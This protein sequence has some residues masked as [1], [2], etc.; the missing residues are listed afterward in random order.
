MNKIKITIFLCVILPVSIF[1]QWNGIVVPETPTESAIIRSSEVTTSYSIG[2]PNIV[3]PFYTIQEGRIK[4]PI[5]LSYNAG[6]FKVGEKA[7]WV[8][9]GWSLST[10]GVVTREMRG[11][12]D[13]CTN[14]IMYPANEFTLDKLLGKAN[15]INPNTLSGANSFYYSI[16]EAISNGYDLFTDVF[17]FSFGN[18]SGKLV[19]DQKEC[20]FLLQPFSD[21]RFEQVIN[22]DGVIEGWIFYTPDGL[23]YTFGID[24]TDKTGQLESTKSKILSYGDGGYMDSKSSEIGLYISA[25]YLMKITD[26]KS[27]SEVKF[28]YSSNSLKSLVTEHIHTSQTKVFNSSQPSN[29][30]TNTILERTY[31]EKQCTSITFSE[32][33]VKFISDSK[34]RNDLTNSHALSRLELHAKDDVLKKAFVFNYKYVSGESYSPFERYSNNSIMLLDIID[35]IGENN[36]KDNPYQFYYN[37]IPLPNSMSFAQDFWGF[38]NGKSRASSLIP[39]FY[40]NGNYGYIEE[41]DRSVSEKYSK[42]CIL[43]KIVFPTGGESKF[44]YENNTVKTISNINTISKTEKEII[45][46]E[47]SLPANINI[48]NSSELSFELPERSLVTFNTVISKSSDLDSRILNPTSSSFYYKLSIKTPDGRIFNLNEGHLE[49]TLDKGRYFLKVTL[50]NPPNNESIDQNEQT[51]MVAIKYFINKTSD[52][53]DFIV[54]GLRIKEIINNFGNGIETKTKYEY[55]GGVL[56]SE[57]VFIEN[58]VSYNG[59][60]DHSTVTRIHSSSLTPMVYNKGAIIAYRNVREILVGKEDSIIKDYE[61][62]THPIDNGVKTSNYGSSEL[63]Y[64]MNLTWKRGELLSEKHYKKTLNNIIYKR[65]LNYSV[66]DY[67]DGISG[68]NITYGINPPLE[69][70]TF[71]YAFCNYISEWYRKSQEIVTTYYNGDSITLTKDYIYNNKTGIPD[72]IVTKCNGGEEFK[73]ILY[74]P[75]NINNFV[76]KYLNKEAVV[77]KDTCNKYYSISDLIASEKY[78]NNVLV[79]TN[80]NNYVESDGYILLD[81]VYSGYPMLIQNVWDIKYDTYGN[82]IS[83]KTR[84]GIDH[85]LLYDISNNKLIAKLDGINLDQ[86]TTFINNKGFSSENLCKATFEELKN[87][88]DDMRIYFSA[89]SITTYIHEPLVGVKEITD[90]NGVTAYY[91]YDDFG[92][93]ESVLDNEQNILKSTKY[94]YKKD[95]VNSIKC[96]SS[97]GGSVSYDKSKDYFVGSEI[98]F[99][100]KPDAKFVLKELKV[101]GILVSNCSDYTLNSLSDS[102]VVEALFERNVFNVKLLNSPEG[103]LSTNNIT[104]VIKGG[105]VNIRVTPIYGYIVSAIKVNGSIVITN[106]VC[107]IFNYQL[108]SITSDIEISVLYNKQIYNLNIN[109]SLFCIPS[110]TTNVSH[111]D[112]FQFFPE[113]VLGHYI[114]AIYRNGASISVTYPLVLSNITDN[115]TINIVHSPYT[116]S[117]NVKD[118]LGRN[119]A[120][121]DIVAYTGSSL[122]SNDFISLGSAI[123][124]IN[125]N[126]TLVFSSK[127]CL[128]G[129]DSQNIKIGIR[130]NSDYE[131]LSEYTFN[132]NITNYNFI[133]C[134]LR[135]V[136]IN[137]PSYIIKYEGEEITML[138]KSCSS[139]SI[140]SSINWVNFSVSKGSGDANIVVNVHENGSNSDREG[141]FLVRFKSKIIQVTIKQEKKVFNGLPSVD[142]P[143]NL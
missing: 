64:P 22:S 84:E 120:N 54:G 132:P 111:G 131:F 124:D 45:F 116:I 136:S 142:I 90:P 86:L 83:Y 119:V 117:G 87:M 105:I 71:N 93:L 17:S 139:W 67:R 81:N 113:K 12:P 16:K 10:G 134:D 4:V 25:W 88:F 76:N 109:Y 99:H 143:N 21:I 98:V 46:N 35:V 61:F 78:K 18:Y 30:P 63:K 28:T 31:Y 95:K 91:E 100:I 34:S 118:H 107:G 44:L 103:E 68:I 73:D 72:V 47:T 92:R 135:E 129:Q 140:V 82:L 102:C 69:V 38:Y 70:M 39:T 62:T 94:N 43:E 110:T 11:I 7:S 133:G 26:S 5:S 80:I 123:T 6:G 2:Q 106:T 115:T 23:I 128:S 58:N 36:V 56:L 126:Y 122:L 48:F 114:S 60:Y 33:V 101:N 40:A 130:S 59:K 121:A 15:L 14:G 37:S 65:V 51:F 66:D 3:V 50:D 57:P 27:K 89:G 112:K 138:L 104:E 96:I 85:C 141:V 49:K 20:K 32:G 52:N 8:G 29:I 24:G 55:S 42:A 13:D 108:K 75:F 127:N 79:E 19:F 41:E 137:I 125:G 53:K 1:S 9:L 74:Y 97:Y 77:K